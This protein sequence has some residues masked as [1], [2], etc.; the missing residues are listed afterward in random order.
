[1]TE[2]NNEWNVHFLH[3][4]FG[5]QHSYTCYFSIYQSSYEIINRFASLSSA[6]F[7]CSNFPEVILTFSTKN[8]PKYFCILPANLLVCEIFTNPNKNLRLCLK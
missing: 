2:M 3:C 8:C 1:M 5:I 4:T 6:I 7:Q